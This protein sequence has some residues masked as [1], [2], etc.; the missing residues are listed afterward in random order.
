MGKPHRVKYV[1]LVADLVSSRKIVE[2]S[3]VQEKLTTCLRRLNS[4]KKEGLLSPYTI[5]LG[6]EFQ[7]VFATPGRIFRDALTVLIALYPVEVRFVF[8][9]GEI[10]TSINSKQTLGMDG[11][12]FHEA[13]GAIE[14]LKKAKGLFAVAGPEPA[15]LDLVNHSLAL[16]SHAIRKWP[17]S[18]LEILR[19]ILEHRSVG[20]LASDLGITDK[21][22][23]KSIDAGAVRT[24]APIFD[25]IIMR[26]AALQD[27]SQ[28]G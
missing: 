23:Y 27:G 6:D 28:H 18:R 17:R 2:R 25:E 24:I 5:T 14:R 13:R 15:G 4:G 16:V 7:S 12:A 11:P 10:S 22:V 9:V 21:A 26:I 20:Q 1:V 8:A 3:A 19:G